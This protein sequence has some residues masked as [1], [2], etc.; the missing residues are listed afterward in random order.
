MGTV[1]IENPINADSG[2][3][4]PDGPVIAPTEVR[5][6]LNEVAKGCPCTYFKE[7]ERIPTKYCIDEQLDNFLIVSNHDIPQTLVKCPLTVIQD[8][9]LINDGKD[10]I[11]PEVVSNLQP[12]EIDCFFMVV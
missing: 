8:I 5:A 4:C 12:G 7:G 2:A 6:F 9:Y 3:P 10:F 11:P 1:T